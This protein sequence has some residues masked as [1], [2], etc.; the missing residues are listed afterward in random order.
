MGIIQGEEAELVGPVLLRVERKEFVFAINGSET[1]VTSG[2]F[3]L[4]EGGDTVVELVDD[5][6]KLGMKDGMVVDDEDADMIIRDMAENMLLVGIV[7]AA[8]AAA[9]EAAAKAEDTLLLL[10]AGVVV[11]AAVAAVD[12]M[13]EGATAIGAFNDGSEVEKGFDPVLLQH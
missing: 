2:V 11:A 12:G 3:G 10:D 4:D 1:F 7:A 8:A 5:V 13:E 6:E 9:P